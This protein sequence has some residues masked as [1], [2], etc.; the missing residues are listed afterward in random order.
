MIFS[1]PV[2]EIY[3]YEYS[4]ADKLA[5]QNNYPVVY[6]DGIDVEEI[7][8]MEL[9]EDNRMAVGKT[10]GITPIFF[11]RF[12]N[13]TVNWEISN[14]DI[15]SFENGIITALSPGTATLT[16]SVGEVSD[17][18]EIT[19]FQLATSFAVYP[20]EA[21]VVAK[22]AISFTI[23]D[24]E[25]EGS[26]ATISWTSS[27][28]NLATVDDQG[29][30]KTWKPGTV[31]ISAKSIEGV[32][33]EATLHLC[34]AV[35]GITFE[36]A[37]DEI[38]AGSA[39]QLL[40]KVTTK[41]NNAYE[42][43]LVTF[44][45]SDENILKVDE[46]GLVTGVAPGTATVTALASNGIS[47]SVSVKVVCEN[48]TVVNDPEIPAT[49]EEVGW[50][51]G[52][53]CSAC[54]KVI[55]AQQEIPALNHQWGDPTYTWSDDNSQVTATRVCAHDVEHVET[56]T[57]S[58]T[59]ETTKAATCEA[60][61]ETT[62][63][64]AAFGNNAF[65]VQTVTVDNIPAL[66]HA[67]GEPTYSW[68]TDNGQVTA[69]RVCGRD[70]NHKEEEAVGTTSEVTKAA[71]CETLGETTYSAAF[72]N[73]AFAPQ[74][75]T[76]E[77]IPAA[78][79]HPVLCDR[80]EST[81]TST[82]TEAYYKCDACG[83]I[84]GDAEGENRI[85]APVTIAM[86]PHT[87]MEHVQVGAT[88]TTA[89]TEAYWSCEVCKKLFSDADGQNEI[90]TPIVIPANGH[91]LT[92]HARVEASCTTSGVEAYWECADCKMLFSD[93]GAMQE[94]SA[95]AAIPAT[96]HQATVVAGHAATCT[97][98]GL[99]EG[100]K[101]SVCGVILVAQNVVPAYGHNYQPNIVWTGVDA[102]E[103]TMTCS[104]DAGH[105]V[106][107]AMTVTSEDTVQPGDITEGVRTYTATAEF[108]GKTYSDSKTEAIPPL[109]D[110]QNGV[111]VAYRG[112]ATA[113]VV[114][115]GVT[116][117]G[118]GAFKGMSQITS[119]TLPASLTS[120]GSEA[121]AGT[122]IT[123]VQISGSV[124]EIGAG[125]FDAGTRVNAPADSAAMAW[126]M[127]NGCADPTPEPTET[128]APELSVGDAF[129]A[130]G[131]K[132]KLTS[133][134]TAAFQGTEKTGSRS[135]VVIPQTVTYGDETYK[136]T[137]IGAGAFRKDTKITT[138]TVGKNVT[139]I[140]KD[141]FNGCSKLA[142]VKA[143]SAVTSI[144]DGAFSGCKA[145]KAL[146]TMKK[147]QTIGANAFKGC[148]KLTKI[149]LEAKVQSI[150]KNAFNGCKALKTIQV[151][152][153]LLTTKNVGAGAFKGISSKA[154][155]KCPKA[156]KKAYEKLF[157]K[158]GAP[159]TCSFK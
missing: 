148:V 40:A 151:K 76:L 18:M 30:V 133:A 119:V 45:S 29:L 109:M 51:A 81:C 113:I 77:N 23:A 13:M 36:D 103:L 152:T 63:T 126:A 87:L 31:T 155:F 124:T 48:H 157:R 101:C 19:V 104:H 67:W 8:T 137:E 57:V 71:G 153:T 95:P 108:E 22:D 136:I 3:C 1:D 49:C 144:G 73:E 44:A 78:G 21:W 134:N 128:P 125:A 66:E 92:A 86:I 117:I 147:L 62:Y 46:N 24:M 129:Q 88:D 16:A 100:K 85:E 102:C 26:D 52:S 17:S 145:L 14:S 55:I 90:D 122:G 64:S 142:T 27:D 138:V 82:G 10:L 131:M 38:V 112:N 132:Y 5:S 107:V 32:H 7:K 74:S 110:I 9:P 115:E 154:T 93:A 33:A 118:A 97:E 150:G 84:F 158:K 20:T 127:A 91:K 35:Q 69:T 105:V 79:H 83:A 6:L 59:T 42:N 61:G 139:K 60:K 80:I 58:T 159:K 146:P 111:L 47:A 28:I 106:R 54:G 114:P 41:D 156:E 11:P 75:K 68:S 39:V 96:G 43:K 140:G 70:E 121:F 72:E 37:D 94:I 116:A 15:I 123:E 53:H 99:T 130:D 65:T 12:R 50:T 98:N 56:E 149:V 135:S 120:I 2:P 141:A 34:Y 143:G 89:G 25:P 4:D